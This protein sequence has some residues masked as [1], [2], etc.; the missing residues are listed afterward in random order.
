MSSLSTTRD[1]DS[2]EE[3]RCALPGLALRRGGT[4]LTDR[5]REAEI[6]THS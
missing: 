1:S 5:G 4:I 2:N 3:R 6:V